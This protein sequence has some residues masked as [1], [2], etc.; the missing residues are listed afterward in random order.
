MCSLSSYSACEPKE[1]A[2]SVFRI[3]WQKVFSQRHFV[4]LESVRECWQIPDVLKFGLLTG[5]QVR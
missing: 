2:S 4:P 1:K 5:N 3:N